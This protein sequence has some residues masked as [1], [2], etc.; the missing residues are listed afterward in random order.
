MQN[1]PNILPQAMFTF[2]AIHQ[3][4]GNFSWFQDNLLT[5]YSN[6]IS[7]S[8]VTLKAVWWSIMWRVYFYQLILAALALS[9]EEKA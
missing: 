4:S 8:P 5:I 7:L 6:D 9:K 1:P 3:D 2:K